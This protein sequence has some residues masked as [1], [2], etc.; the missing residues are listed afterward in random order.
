MTGAWLG[1][2]IGASSSASYTQ[3]I[4]DRHNAFLTFVRLGQV[5]RSHSSTE[6]SRK[7]QR[8]SS[9]CRGGNQ[10]QML[11]NASCRPRTA[12]RVSHSRGHRRSRVKASVDTRQDR[13]IIT[14]RREHSN[15]R[16]T[17]FRYFVSRCEWKG[18]RSALARLCRSCG[19]L[20][21]ARG[22]VRDPTSNP[23]HSLHR[24]RL[25]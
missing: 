18:R 9:P 24:N 1:G 10:A 3:V 11:R 5:S 20:R 19:S 23:S 2:R 22:N 8:F 6:F 17:Q 14:S 13:R 21:R 16:E 25:R 4:S 7:L 15:L 12:D